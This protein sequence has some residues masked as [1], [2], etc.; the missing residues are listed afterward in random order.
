[1]IPV[2]FGADETEFTTQGLG[3]LTD[4]I[5][6][7]V[8]EERNGIF[9]LEMQYPVTGIHYEDIQYRAI[10][11]AIPSPYRSRQ[12]FR[13]YKI[14]R[15]LD[16]VV[17]VYAA[18]LSY[19]LN[20]IPVNPFLAF[21]AAAAMGALKNS[22]AI[23]NNFT[24]VSAI[25][26]A[27]SRI[28]IAAPTA[29]RTVLGGMQGSFLDVF[30][31]EYE[32][33][34]WI[35]RLWAH[36]GHDNGVSIRYGKNMTALTAETDGENTVTGIYPYWQK[37]GVLVICDPPIIWIDDEPFQKAVPV[38]FSADF[39]EQPTPAQLKERAEQ[40]ISDN[41]IGAVPVSIDV[42]FVQLAQMSGYEDIAVLERCDLCDIVTVQYEALGVDVKSEIVKITTDVLKER[43]ESMQVGTVRADVAQ[44]IADT[45]NRVNKV[46]RPD[47][48]LVAEALR[49]FI[50]LART[51]LG[52]MY[53]AASP[54]G[55]TA[56]LFE[57][58][59]PA[60]P[61]YGAMATGTSGLM[62]AGEKKED[63]TG[64][65]WETVM[66][67]KGVIADMIVAGILT[68]KLGLNYWNLDT[69][70]FSLSA[71]A[72]VGGKEIASK[73]ETIQRVDVEYASGT[74]SKT[75]PES[76]WS[77]TAPEWQ[78]GRYIWQRTVTTMADGTQAVSDPTCIQGAAG[79]DGAPG[80]D[81]VGISAIVEQYYLSNSASTQTGGSWSTD[82]P[83]WQKGKYIWTRSVITWTNGT[84]TETDP[85]L[86]K[87]I[88]GANE[89]VDDLDE[90]LDQEG[91]F[92][93]L[94]N[95]GSAQGIYMQDGKLYINGEYIVTG[96]ISSRNG[97]VYF[98]LDNS[99]LR[100]SHLVSENTGAG[101]D[102]NAIIGRSFF[103]G[104]TETSGYQNIG[105]TVHK[106][107][108][109]RY[110]V[111]LSPG[112]ENTM[113]G[114]YSGANGM[115][116]ASYARNG[117]SG[118]AGISITQKGFLVLSSHH[119]YSEAQDILSNTWAESNY[120]NS[121]MGNIII[122][123]R[124]NVDGS[125]YNGWGVIYING[126]AD[127]RNGIEAA[128]LT[129]T[130]TKNRSITTDNYGDRLQYCYETASP[131]FGDIGEALTDENGECVIALDDIF[132][133]TVTSTIEY[134]VF[135]QKEGQGDLWVDEKTERYFTVK[136][137]ENLKFSWEVK[138]KQK[139]YEYD[140][141]DERGELYPMD[142]PAPEMLYEN[143]VEKIIKEQ[144]A[145]LYEAVKQFYGSEHQRR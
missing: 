127:F 96:K 115:T 65:D 48:S 117:D 98:D 90:S 86:A 38:D 63:G 40:Y 81:G 59:D 21:G 111:A 121:R 2:L 9:E 103:G 66:T 50:D 97:R 13:V 102:M 52:A 120:S 64:W 58:N 51:Q 99:E 26:N 18:H 36:R 24:F 32:W 107:N 60:S 33:D 45:E 56:I 73:A 76:G 132:S 108:L 44:T 123:P 131:M 17:T 109:S 94:T 31:G 89:A 61:N 77:T 83:A 143:E 3:A 49:G 74:S 137:T 91:V 4:A 57:N 62:I 53:D 88:N 144:E 129:V 130:G 70:D 46:V 14:T 104:A 8:T 1:M 68:D 101:E 125:V 6:C 106:T 23:N 134:Q 25:T 87:A 41:D 71:A 124:Y 135:L 37:E 43:Y 145:V 141:L 22:M 142:E 139:D 16:G 126:N 27:T 5:S 72:T 75:P 84:T 138:V 69:G 30:G 105:F 35:V 85:V 116:Y 93:R 114:V 79:T 29:C 39:E 10:I 47:G 122:A 42:S 19:D 110:G 112:D 67:F 11:A 28:S 54:A 133:E 82:Q 7:A 140:R 55:V 128:S 78:S 136:G 20:A 118:M 34:T 92:N 113:P 95:N 12:P 119:S 80:S 15:P 100:C